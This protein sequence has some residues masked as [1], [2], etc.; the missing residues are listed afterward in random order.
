[1][2][3]DLRDGQKR[4]PDNLEPYLVTARRLLRDRKELQR[5]EAYL[6]IYLSQ[7]PEYGATPHSLAKKDLKILKA[8]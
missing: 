2:E 7:E 6:N 5:A 3:S 8:L 4:V 1:M